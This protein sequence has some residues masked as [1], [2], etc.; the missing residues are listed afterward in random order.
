MFVRTT[1]KAPY[2]FRQLLTTAKLLISCLPVVTCSQKPSTIA[3][4][5]AI[6][7]FTQVVSVYFLFWSCTAQSFTQ[8]KCTF[9]C[10]FSTV[11]WVI[12]EETRCLL[13]RA[14]KLMCPFGS[15]EG[16]LKNQKHS[17]SG[18]ATVS[19]LINLNPPLSSPPRYSDCGAVKYQE[20]MC[21]NS[22]YVRAGWK[23]AIQPWSQIVC[24]LLNIEW[25]SCA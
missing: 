17:A 18:T 20:L 9:R 1:Y 2:C 12:E 7:L 19:P 5:G 14:L 4:W 21:L 22:C 10:R 11:G 8:I 3:C 16:D 15:S 25:T 6:H 24:A 13:M 23:N